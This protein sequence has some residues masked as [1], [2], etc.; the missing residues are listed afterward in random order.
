LQSQE[1]DPVELGSKLIGRWPDGRLLTQ[2]TSVAKEQEA[3]FAKDLNGL[4]C[5]IGAHIRRA[6]PRD[7]IV[8]QSLDPIDTSRHRLLRRGRPYGLPCPAESYP[9]GITVTAGGLRSSMKDDRGLVF[10]CLGADIARQFEH[11]QQSW[12]NNSK[13]N[14]LQEEVCPIT[15]A[16]RTKADKR[17]FTIPSVPVRRRIQ[18]WPEV[19]TVI[20]SAYCFM[21]GR[22]AFDYLVKQ[23]SKSLG[24][25]E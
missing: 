10:A 24:S 25:T 19:V 6:N 8:S 1:G 17:V 5:P 23:S 22:D 15:S 13:H 4:R 16:T 20:G 18:D 11:V 9:A 2:D 3:S 7:S 21:P 14:G 12:L